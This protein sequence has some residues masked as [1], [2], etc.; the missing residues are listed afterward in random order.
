MKRE[1]NISIVHLPQDSMMEIHWNI[2]VIYLMKILR[3]SAYSNSH[4]PNQILNE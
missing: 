3:S 2:Q 4:F 1:W